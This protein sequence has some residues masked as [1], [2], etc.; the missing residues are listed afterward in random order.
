MVNERTNAATEKALGV[1]K[2][3]TDKAVLAMKEAG[4]KT[5]DTLRQ[6]ATDLG[7]K[8]QTVAADT[9][10]TVKRAANAHVMSVVVNRV[11]GSVDW[12]IIMAGIGIL[13][14]IASYVMRKPSRIRDM[15]AV[16]KHIKRNDGKESITAQLTTLLEP[17][18]MDKHEYSTIRSATD[19]LSTMFLLPLLYVKGPKFAFQMGQMITGSV[20]M[21]LNTWQL[22]SLVR[23]WFSNDE[24]P[25][26]VVEANV[27]AIADRISVMT[28]P[29]LAAREE[30]E[31]NAALVLNPNDERAKRDLVKLRAARDAPPVQIDKGNQF[32]DWA[33]ENRVL[34][35]SFIM[36]IIAIFAGAAYMFYQKRKKT[37]ST[38]I[39]KVGEKLVMVNDKGQAL[40]ATIGRVR[41][42]QKQLQESFPLAAFRVGGRYEGKKKYYV[43]KN[44][45]S[46]R[47][48]VYDDKGRYIDYIDAFDNTDDE[49]V[50]EDREDLLEVE[51]YM[52]ANGHA[53]GD[54]TGYD[55]N[56][57][58]DWTRETTNLGDS[59]SFNDRM[60]AY[61]DSWRPNELEAASKAPVYFATIS[62]PVAHPVVERAKITTPPRLYSQL[63]APPATLVE[64]V[65]WP[66]APTRVPA[67]KPTEPA[68]KKAIE[69]LTIAAAKATV[70][71]PKRTPPAKP[72]KPVA[73]V[74]PIV[75]ALQ[76]RATYW[77][78]RKMTSDCSFGAKCAVPNCQFVHPA[79][80]RCY[81]P[82]CGC[83][84][85]HP[86]TF[87]AR[88]DKAGCDQTCGLFHRK[89][90]VV[91]PKQKTT[92]SLNGLVP[93]TDSKLAKSLGSLQAKAADGVVQGQAFT[94]ANKVWTAKHCLSDGKHT[95]QI[96]YKD[97]VE[98]P[99]A[100]NV[101][102]ACDGFDIA[103][104]EL[105]IADRPSLSVGKE[106]VVGNSVHMRVFDYNKK[107]W[108][109]ATGVISS[110]D[111]TFL[112]YTIPTDEGY[113]GGAVLDQSGNII[114][115]HTNGAAVRNGPNQGLR[116]T[117]ALVAF[118]TKSKN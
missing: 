91:V 36:G 90:K 4:D 56:D 67:S 95:S 106:P 102:K 104:T 24:S 10:E 35:A 52:N 83:P 98:M 60:R 44:K 116:I 25:A 11:T 48:V 30:A 34:A 101:W 82:W 115:M 71:L 32:W 33:R 49:L 12:S 42:Y 47:W 85:P 28:D 14:F 73:V 8:V 41:I 100:A 64:S 38:H 23:G 70:I 77:L 19:V 93:V 17:V 20:R 99:L 113:S 97:G 37:L 69:S 65:K 1:V 111:S 29:V 103:Y 45:K 109:T 107:E 112:H 57:Y 22:V 9:T 31:L 78:N 46:G 110:F 26:D 55:P 87:K 13:G 105:K 75:P 63:V 27:E 3:A 62:Q 6:A 5:A 2:D 114:A 96:S 94:L 92:E 81:K 74:K 53:L 59:M 80:D 58:A 21:L 89:D 76:P 18:L 117:P 43:S 7:N 51:R 66:P 16:K 68:A 61:G 54:N 15:E 84:Q 79:E 86:F 50:F 39:F 72:V 88:C 108:V 118:L 40:E